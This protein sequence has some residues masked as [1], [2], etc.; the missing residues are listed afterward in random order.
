MVKLWNNLK[1]RCEEVEMG[2]G[3]DRVIAHDCKFP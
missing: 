2:V 3:K 1:A